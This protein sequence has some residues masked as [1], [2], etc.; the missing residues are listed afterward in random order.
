MNPNTEFTDKFLD[1][2]HQQ[3]AEEYTL[4][5]LKEK[6]QQEEEKVKNLGLF[7]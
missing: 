7:E 6:I 3:F 5:Q 4:S 1:D 2:L